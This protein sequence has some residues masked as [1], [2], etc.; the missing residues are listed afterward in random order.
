[1]NKYADVTCIEYGMAVLAG[2]T[3]GAITVLGSTSLTDVL[4]A[5]PTAIIYALLICSIMDVFRYAERM[6][7]LYELGEG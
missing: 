4:L 6:Y 1:M 5:V 2:I 7:E 3:I